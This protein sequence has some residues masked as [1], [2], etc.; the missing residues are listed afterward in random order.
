MIELD[1]EQ[2]AARA[3]FESLRDRICAA[4]EAVEAEAGSDAR[5]VYTPWDRADPDGS[6]GGG[7]VRGVMNGRIFEKVGVNVST[8]G[9]T[10]EPEFARS[11]HG[12]DQ[13][14]HFFATGIS[15]V[16][17]MANPHVPAVHM[18]TRFLA[19]TK[20]WFGGGADLNPPIPYAEDTAD[21]HAAMQAACDPQVAGDYPRFKA[22]ADD[23]FYIPHRG[24]HRGVGGIFYDHLEGDFD[25]GFAFTK[26]VG[27]AFLDVF[28]R[29][30][31]RRM[32]MQWTE[33]DKARQLEWR[34]RYAEFNL[35]YDR[36]TAFGLKT[37]GNVDAILMSLP[38][39]ATWR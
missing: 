33:A 19:T 32:H 25:A 14:P 8:V 13:D 18:N 11:I 16:A 4:F 29:L 20:R 39:E 34:G 2:Q 26:A 17:H 12:A 28:P 36:G 24:V 30:V 5:F 10:F 9:G 27:E 31:R 15:L 6:P 21:F 7:G 1:D 22:W 35:V 23:Y 3:W 37:G 38:P